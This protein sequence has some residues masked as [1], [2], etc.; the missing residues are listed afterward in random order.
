VK[1]Q[2]VGALLEQLGEVQTVALTT[3]QVLDALLL[4]AALEVEATEV[5]TRRHLE[6]ADLEDIKAAGYLF[7]HRLV[8]VEILAAL[9]DEGQLHHI[10][11]LDDAVVRLFVPGEQAD[12]RGSTSAVRD[13]DADNGATRNLEAEVH[14]QHIVT[15]ILADIVEPE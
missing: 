3:G 11:A 2:H 8:A 6:I 10:A 12:Q 15:E 14:V 1:Q 9:V 5:S 7:P 13:D 4:V